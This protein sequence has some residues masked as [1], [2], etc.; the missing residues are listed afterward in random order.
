MEALY[1]CTEASLPILL[2]NLGAEGAHGLWDMSCKPF[3]DI[4][5]AHYGN[6]TVAI[7]IDLFGVL[8]DYSGVFA[9]VCYSA[10]ANTGVA[11]SRDVE[12]AEFS[13]CGCGL[14]FNAHAFYVIGKGGCVDEC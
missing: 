4:V 8:A 7:V 11:K 9:V 10:H 6:S 14:P 5:F 13:K 12:C 3:G 1:F 2:I